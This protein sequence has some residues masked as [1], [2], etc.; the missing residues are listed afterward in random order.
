[1]KTPKQILKSL[2]EDSQEYSVLELLLSVSYT[3]VRDIFIDLCV[4]DPNGVLMHLRKKGITMY[5]KWH[6]NPKS[7]KSYKRFSLNP[8]NVL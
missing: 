1:M 2:K 8:K 6:T 4:N 7:N 3:T 5:D